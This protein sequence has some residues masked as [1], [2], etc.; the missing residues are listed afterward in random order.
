MILSSNPSVAETGK[1][2]LESVSINSS[3][4]QLHHRKK[5]VAAASNPYSTEFAAVGFTAKRLS[6]GEFMGLPET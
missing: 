3:P 6:Q 5:D 4:K 1:K 2:E